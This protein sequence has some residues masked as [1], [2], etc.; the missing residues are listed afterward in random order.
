VAIDAETK[1]LAV[2]GHP[3]GHSLSPALHNRLFAVHRL[4]CVYVACDVASERLPDVPAGIRALSMLGVNVTIPHK[5]AILPLLD[6]VDP[7][8]R[9]VGAVNTVV[10]KSGRLMGYNTD[11]IGFMESLRG[12]VRSGAGAVLGCG[13]VGRAAV[14]GMLRLGVKHIYVADADARRAHRLS[15]DF[16]RR[17][18]AVPREEVALLLDRCSL[19]VNGTP[20]GMQATDPVPVDL[21]RATSGMV[22]YDVI[23]HRTTRLVR[24]ARR[25]GLRAV[26]GLELFAR[27]AAS[28]FTLWTGVRP[29]VPGIITFLR[30]LVSR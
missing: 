23:Y 7:L 28:A 29:S 30:R 15:R 18:T 5:E 20:V 4:N 16:G 21:S 26:D 27:Q 9:E 24:E 2:I 1:L 17:L 22:V 25:R 10:H 14:V 12:L 8:A 11:V 19:F 6:S 13:G 3:I